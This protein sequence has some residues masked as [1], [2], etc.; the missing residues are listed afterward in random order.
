MFTP[1]CDHHKITDEGLMPKTLVCSML[2]FLALKMRFNFVLFYSS[3][4]MHIQI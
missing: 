1:L 2:S 3:I 4:S